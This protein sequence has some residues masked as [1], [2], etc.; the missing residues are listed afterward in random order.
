MQTCKG[1]KSPQDF[2]CE[3]CKRTF[4]RKNALEYHVNNSVCINRLQRRTTANNT[5]N[6]ILKEIVLES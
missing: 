4:K 6:K 5:L 1:P 3:N 2:K